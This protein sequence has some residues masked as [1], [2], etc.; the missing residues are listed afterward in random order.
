MLVIRVKVTEIVIPEVLTPNGD[1]KNDIFNI[2]NIEYFPDNELLIFNRWGNLVYQM[3]GYKNTWDGTPNV[4]GKTGSEKLP[5][6]TY[7]YLLKI[8]GEEVKAYRGF[9]QLVY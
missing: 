4:S 5:T 2:K 3:Q 9:V 1:G 7:F 8:N 6:S